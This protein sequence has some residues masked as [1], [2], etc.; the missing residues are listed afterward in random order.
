MRAKSPLN[1]MISPK[2]NIGSQT[3]PAYRYT[4]AVSRCRI[5]NGPCPN[6]DMDF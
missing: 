3:L 2:H 1:K 4:P 6:A 5:V